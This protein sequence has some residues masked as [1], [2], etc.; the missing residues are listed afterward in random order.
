[1]V[2][3]ERV[4]GTCA[5]L[6]EAIRLLFPQLNDS[7]PVPG[8]AELAALLADPAVT[9]LAAR[10]DGVVVGLAVVSVYRRLSGT[11]ARLD[12]VVVDGPARRHGA[13]AALVAAAI[14]VGRERGAVALEL[15][16]G[17]WRESANRLYPRLGLRRRDTNVYA[18]DL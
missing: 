15:T 9:L 2:A 11:M 3:V 14:E 17:G 6:E 10:V 4:R 13:G 7:L 12:D 1:M 18:L 5:E 8:P 16:S